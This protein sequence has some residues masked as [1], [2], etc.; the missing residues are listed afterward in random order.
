[1]FRHV[2]CTAASA[3]PDFACTEAVAHTF[4][5]LTTNILESLP[6]HSSLF[7]FFWQIISFRDSGSSLL[8][9][10]VMHLGFTWLQILI[11]TMM[12]FAVFHISLTTTAYTPRYVK[13]LA[14][15]EDLTQLEEVSPSGNF[16]RTALVKSLNPSIC[17]NQTDSNRRAA[18]L[19]FQ[20]EVSRT[21]K[22][23]KCN[24]E[25]K[26][27]CASLIALCGATCASAVAE[28]WWEF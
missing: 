9:I 19:A 28:G 20:L 2:S 6:W 1:M 10:C 22:L 21:Q 16:R 7:T 27:A 5:Q 24:W 13:R 23:G 11:V 17:L 3:P 18:I 4:N 14:F 25:Q 12:C 26:I 15:S 8:S